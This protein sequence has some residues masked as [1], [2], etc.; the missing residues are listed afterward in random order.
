MPA[1]LDAINRALGAVALPPA[2]SLEGTVAPHVA[3]A[4]RFVEE[5]DRSAQL[6]EWQFNVEPDVTLPLEPDGT[7]LAPS[8]LLAFTPRG[9]DARQVTT[10]DGLFYNLAERTT[11]FATAL[12]GRLVAQV[13]FADCPVYFREYVACRAARRLQ[14]QLR[15]DPAGARDA[16]AQELMARAD[17]LRHDENTRRSNTIHAEP[18]RRV[19][20]R[21]PRRSHRR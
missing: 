5:E 6:I 16:Q 7:I 14:A 4:R 20:D 21:L 15:G 3:M 1:L 18:V 10:R 11:T 17:A 8:S 13:D 9:D 19:L 12:R 2:S